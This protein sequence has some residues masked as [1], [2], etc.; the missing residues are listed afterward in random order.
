[1]KPVA[2]HGI[3]SR[4][5]RMRA[6]LPFIEDE[7]EEESTDVSQNSFVVEDTD[8]MDISDEVV[9]EEE[10]DIIRVKTEGEGQK[11][12]STFTY[13]ISTAS[14]LKVLNEYAGTENPFQQSEGSDLLNMTCKVLHEYFGFSEDDLPHCKDKIDEAK[15]NILKA[16]ATLQRE[17]ISYKKITT[18]IEVSFAT[19]CPPDQNTISRLSCLTLPSI[20]LA[21][22]RI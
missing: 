15:T 9:K 11:E 16:M 22:H 18:R 20:C 8:P 2:R 1:M 3:E 6:A 10:E 19:G 4:A 12:R 5:A 14:L 21:I 13:N 7:V 17:D